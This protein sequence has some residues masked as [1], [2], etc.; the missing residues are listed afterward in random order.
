[1]VRPRSVRRSVPTA[2]SV[3]A[4][5]LT[6]VERDQ[7]FA[8]AVLD[9]EL[10]RAAQLSLADRRLATELVY[11]VLRCKSYL[12]ERIG[13]HA[14]KGVDR[15]VRVHLRVAVYQ[16]AILERIPAFAAVSAAVDLVRESQGPHAA[17]FANAVLRKIAAEV[18]GG[19]RTPMEEAVRR[20]M[21]PGLIE[22]VARTLGDREQAE[23]LFAAGPFPP[24]LGLRV[25]RAH[26]VDAWAERLRST[27]AGARV[28]R[29]NVCPR[30]LLLSGGG[31]PD[32]LP[33]F[34]TAWS[35]Q[36]EGSQVLGE[37]LGAR[38]GE[39]ILDACAGRGNKTLLVAERVGSGTVDAADLH[40][41]KLDKLLARADRLGLPV[42][43][44]FPVD[45]TVGTG[46][47][48]DGYDRV[49]VDAPCSGTGTTRR[50]PEVLQRDIASTLP[51]L[52][53]LQRKILRNAATRCRPGGRLVYAVCSVLRE[54][55]EEVVQDVLAT[56]VPIE[57]AP[58]DDHIGIEALR[59]EHSVRLLP[60]IHGTDGYFVASFRRS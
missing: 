35:V 25:Y 58:F 44:T 50:R 28:E 57:P 46:E 6:R 34:E 40:E 21:N 22:R 56:G 32:D 42:K 30:C 41:S 18:D 2:R 52:N 31:R 5:V 45:W 53:E 39:R 49:L 37:A 29:G 55:A 1:M 51:T 4:D 59:G 27:V 10:D 47:V 9:V 33:G 16:L 20:S 26:D 48:P 54:E 43:H 23:A 15:D 8:S 24:P 14:R 17:R 11:G 7:A 3:A 36:E 60:H 12:D 38:P 13:R 19:G